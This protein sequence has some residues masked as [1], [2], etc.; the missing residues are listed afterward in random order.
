MGLGV[1]VEAMF[2]VSATY[3]RLPPAGVKAL[4]SFEV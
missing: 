2:A 1:F 4:H 3:A